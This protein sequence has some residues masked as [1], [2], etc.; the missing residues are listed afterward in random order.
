MPAE[1]VL[2]PTHFDDDA[3]WFQ[4]IPP[5]VLSPITPIA[6]APYQGDLIHNGTF[7]ALDHIKAEL[8]QCN[9][10]ESLKQ[11]VTALAE[12]V[13][14]LLERPPNNNSASP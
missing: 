14:S 7:V 4:M 8:P 5:P 12:A 2:P 10:I 11:Q 1:P 9:D 6:I 13:Q 3:L